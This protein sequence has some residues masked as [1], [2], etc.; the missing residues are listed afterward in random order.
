MGLEGSS[1]DFMTSAMSTGTHMPPEHFETGKEVKLTAK[2]DIY[3]AGVL[4]WQTLCGKSPFAGLSPSQVVVA[5]INGQR[6]TLPEETPN[7][8]RLV[9]TRCTESDPALRPSFDELVE[10][11]SK[12]L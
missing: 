4:L 7:E 1:V 2:A 5:V 3:A 12:A 10:T 11:F 6:L 8:I 9:F